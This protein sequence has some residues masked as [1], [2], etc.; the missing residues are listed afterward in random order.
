MN[1]HCCCCRPRERK[2]LERTGTLS[3]QSAALMHRP[4][5]DNA[6]TVMSSSGP[7]PT[8]APPGAWRDNAATAVALVTLSSNQVMARANVLYAAKKLALDG[9]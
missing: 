1:E 8:T 4:R 2:K 6:E 9:S 3:A 5:D 7:H